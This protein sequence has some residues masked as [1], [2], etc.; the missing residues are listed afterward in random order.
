MRDFR[1]SGGTCFRTSLRPAIAFPNRFV[2]S[3]K[4]AVSYQPGATPQ[5]SHRTKNPS[6]E[7]AIHC[8]V[9]NRAFSADGDLGQGPGA[10]SQAGNEIAP[11]ALISFPNRAWERGGAGK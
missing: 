11:L 5:G 6:A 1:L 3:A 8:V 4:G 2:F 7:S 10:M 9:L